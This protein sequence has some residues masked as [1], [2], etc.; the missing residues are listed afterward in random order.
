MVIRIGVGCITAVELFRSPSKEIQCVRLTELTSYLT[1]SWYS[2]R[3]KSMRNATPRSVP[4][5]EKCLPGGKFPTANRTFNEVFD[6]FRKRLRTSRGITLVCDC[7]SVPMA[8]PSRK[9]P[10]LPLLKHF[11]IAPGR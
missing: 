3:G 2:L 10:V 4:R 11:G 7:F 9:P 8:L 1:R 6:S 5:M